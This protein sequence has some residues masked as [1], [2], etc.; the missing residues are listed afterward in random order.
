MED[1]YIMLDV[2][3][4]TLIDSVKLLP[5]LFLTYL[6]MEYIEHKTTA[7]TKR[8]IKNSGKAGPLIGAVLGAFPQCGF[9]AAASNLY[10][11][12]VITL[13][14]LIS[15]YLSTSDEML[16]VF[17]SE[18]VP[19]S[20]IIMIIGW[21]IVIGMAAGFVI[22]FVMRKAKRQEDIQK[23]I[24][25][26]CDHDH[27]HCEDGIL[28]SSV[29]H[30]VVILGYIILVSFVLNTVIYFVGEETLGNLILNK[31]VLGPAIAAIV[32][33]IPNCASS[34][35]ITQLYIGGVMSIGSA[36]AGLLAGCGVGILVLFKENR[37]VKENIKI[38][39]LLYA[40]GLFSGIIIDA[41]C[42]FF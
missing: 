35:V 31:P 15:I 1:N 39:V 25:H 34:V 8:M 19:V 30:T 42:S 16:P 36:M 33:L 11:G 5:F 32:G 26:I 17:L 28:K 24:G 10:A 21:K 20:T 41:V 12:R 23:K 18:K 4:D 38:L 14:T 13:G 9:S 22:D 29:K 2:I 37:D 3:L 27:C 40:L 6:A 7:K